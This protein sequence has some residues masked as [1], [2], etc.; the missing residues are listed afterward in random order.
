MKRD[1]GATSLRSAK[2]RIRHLES[3]VEA[4][5]MINSTLDLERLLSLILDVALENTYAEA[6][7]IYIVEQ[8]KQE[9]WSK[10]TDCDTKIE[11]RL[12]FGRGIAGTVAES[13]ETVNIPDA[14]KD[15]RFNQGIDEQTGFRTKS[16]LCM[17]MR[18]KS[19]DIIGVFQILNK[20]RG[21]FGGE[22]NEAFIQAPY[23]FSNCIFPGWLFEWT[24]T[25][26]SIE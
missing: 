20:K 12:P 23:V 14:Y 4:S 15:S 21:G 24:I 1:A 22:D 3:L 25:T 6:G 26:R 9:L 13:G 5:K 16:I 10:V 2:E 7:T 8:D 11:I 17:P 19:G 18:N